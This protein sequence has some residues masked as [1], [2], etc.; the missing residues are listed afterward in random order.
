LLYIS[1]NA[2]EENMKKPKKCPKCNSPDDIIPI[3]YGYPYSEMKY[4][5]AAGK[6]ELGGCR[7]EPG[8]PDWRCKK[9]NHRW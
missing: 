4:D 1:K 6:I 7:V 5:W 8:N 2:V 9:C 3:K